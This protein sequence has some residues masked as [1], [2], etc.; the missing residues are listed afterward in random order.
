MSME[1]LIY[2][3]FNL[4]SSLFSA[5]WHM[6][7]TKT[8][9]ETFEIIPSDTWKLL[10][11]ILHYQFGIELVEIWILWDLNKNNSQIWINFSFA[12][13][14]FLFL[15]DLDQFHFLSDL[16]QFQFFFFSDLDQFQFFV[17]FGP[18]LVFVCCQIWTNFNFFRQIWINS[19]FVRFWS[20]PF[21][22]QIWTNSSFFVRFGPFQFFC[23]ILKKKL[24]LTSTLWCRALRNLSG[25]KIVY[26]LK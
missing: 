16:D 22:C 7:G 21:F 18:I 25:W 9:K 10:H 19:I 23:Q 12:L 14:Q 5:C 20:I 8:H 15:S 24:D 17:S 13:L 1:H 4:K 26:L 6:K 11:S 2:A 3:P